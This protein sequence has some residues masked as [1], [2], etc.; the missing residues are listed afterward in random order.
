MVIAMVFRW[1]FQ[2]VSNSF[3]MVFQCS[4]LVFQMVLITCFY[5]IAALDIILAICT[6]STQF[7]QDYCNLAGNVFCYGYAFTN[8]C[9]GLYQCTIFAEMAIK[10]KVLVSNRRSVDEKG[11]AN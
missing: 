5:V 11:D 8:L 9:L 4:T 10:L 2:Q 6:V 7:I 1:F 3:P